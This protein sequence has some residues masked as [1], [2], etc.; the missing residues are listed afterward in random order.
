[1]GNPSNGPATKKWFLFIK[2]ELH[3]IAPPGGQVIAPNFPYFVP[4]YSDLTLSCLLQRK[5][6][7]ITLLAHRWRHLVVS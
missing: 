2:I 3:Q 7:K 4:T 5:M 1:M 6:D